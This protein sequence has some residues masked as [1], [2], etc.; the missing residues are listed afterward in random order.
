VSTGIA[1]TSRITTSSARASNEVKAQR[2]PVSPSDLRSAIGS[3]YKRVTGSVPSSA[4][5]D[6]LT[7]QASLETAGGSK[8]Y[9]YNFGGIKGVSPQ[10]DTANYLTHEVI[11]GHNLTVSQ[12]F[13]AYGSIDAGAED[14]VRL[15]SHRY[16]AA[17]SSANVGNVRG[18]AHALKQAGYYT[19]SEDQYASALQSLTGQ[20]PTTSA[21]LS[22][23]PSIQAAVSGAT[24][25]GSED[26]S[27]VLDA[28]SNSALRIS[29]SDQDDR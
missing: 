22:A 15:L 4:L 29:A 21:S 10:G 25:P 28:I 6:T 3:A 9:N 19:A 23:V 1:A 16:G 11:D 5:L 2:T 27:R 14:Y 26:L 12:G 8:M 18:F 17:L 20:Q 13:R 24:Y 7:A